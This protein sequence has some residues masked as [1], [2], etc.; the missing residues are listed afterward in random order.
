MPIEEGVTI[1]FQPLEAGLQGAAW[2]CDGC[3]SELRR[4]EWEHD[5]NTPAVEYYAAACTRFSADEAARTC[6]KCGTVAAP[7]DLAAFGWPPAAAS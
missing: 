4:Y 3:D 7:L 6:D 1:R 2:Y 5:N